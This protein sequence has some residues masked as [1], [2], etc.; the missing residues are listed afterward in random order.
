MHIDCDNLVLCNESDVEQKVVMPLLAGAAYLGIPQDRIFTKTYLAPTILDKTAGRDSGYFPDYSIWM[1]G[2]PVLVVEAKAPEV[3]SETGYR[4]ASLYARHLNVRYRTDLN[5]CRFIVSTNGCELLFGHWDCEP[6]LRITVS[7]LRPGSAHLATLVERCGFARLQAFSLSCL[8]HARAA[9]SFYSYEAAGGSALLN[10]RRGPN[11]FAAGLSP[12]LRRYF[13]SSTQES[14]REIVERAYVSSSEITEYDRILEALLKERLVTRTSPLTQRLEPDHHREEH[15]AHA[16]QEFSRARP[17]GGQLQ[18]IQGA[19]GSGKSL[20]ARRYKEV[21]QPP[22]HAERCRWSF[23]DF[24]ASPTDLCHAEQWL[25]KAF[26]DAFEAENPAIDLYSKGVLKGI[27]SRNI[28]KRKYV[29]EELGRNAP[30]EATTVRANDLAKWQDNPEE[31]AEGL[32]NYVLGISQET[33][34]VVMDNVDR[35]DLK[36][37]L[38]AFQLTLWFMHKT[39]AFVIL[40]MRDETYERYKNQPPL[41]T[42]RTGVTFHISPPRFI[43]VVKKRLE[44]SLEYLEAQAEER[45][46]FAIES[47]AR[48]V[49]HKSQLQ[50]FLRGLYSELFDRKRNISRVLESLAGRDVRRALEMFVSIITSGYLSPAAIASTAIGGSPL[51]ISEREIIKI[52]M[53]TEYSFFSDHS[54]FTSNIFGYDPDWQKPDNFLLVELLYD[55]ARSRKRVGH[56]GLEG[57]FTCR[58]IAEGM[59]KFG[60]VPEDTLAALNLLLKRQLIA[61]DHMNFVKVEFDDSVRI[62][63]SGFIH[64]RVLARRIEY[65]Y[66]ILTTTPLTDRAVADRLADVIKNESVRRSVSSHQTA[67][68]VELFFKYLIR[69]K[70][71]LSNPFLESADTGRQYVLAGIEDALVRFRNVH[72]RPPVERDVLDL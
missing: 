21:L 28:Q 43:D 4:D 65:L 31:M 19:V 60:Y 6:I 12:L 34:I 18:I 37:Q 23:V 70:Q 68:A 44:L 56:I 16:I 11:S 30:N 41:D 40:Q 36:S 22:E 17:E 55:L 29:Y 20:F 71:F 48:V 62:L 45:Q 1:H 25:C 57:Y 3:P 5:P 15:V 14:T 64:V 53:R 39:K 42:F 69:E 24:N 66:G 2:F 58:S 46:G 52:T 9:R 51:S 50:A 26:I 35:L 61:A 38:D 8:V 27:F 32:A 13:F 59:Q 7:D 49:Y 63:A 72:V 67:E 47:G 33:L 10:A 54:G